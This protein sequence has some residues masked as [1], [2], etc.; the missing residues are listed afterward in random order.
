MRYV[1]LPAFIRRGWRAGLLGGLLLL[2]AGAVQA[3]SPQILVPGLDDELAD[4]IRAFLSI[5][6]E[7]CELVAWRERHLLGRAEEEARDA[8]R[9]FGYYRPEITLDLRRVAGCWRLDVHVTPGERVRV[10]R[11]DVTL[12]GAAAEDPAFEA[13]LADAPLKVG[14]PLRHD[15]YEDLRNGLTRLAADR[16]YFDSRILVRELRIDTG[17][18][19]ADAVIHLDSGPRYAFGEVSLEQDILHPERLRKFLPFAEGEPYEARR[20]ID[21]QQRLVDSDY[22]SEV[23]VRTETEARA[24]GRVPILVTLTPRKRH[25]YLA[26]IG[27]STDI[28]PRLRLGFENRYANQLGHRYHFDLALSPVRSGAG[29]NYEIP[30]ADPTRERINLLTRYQTEETDT[31]ESDIFGV[32]ISHSRQYLSG[33]V[34]TRSLSFEREDYTVA[35]V[36]DRSD[37]LMP[38]FALTRVHADHPLNP[39]R[40]WKLYGSTRGA[41]EE[42]GSTVSFAQFHGRAKLILPLGTGRLITRAEGGATLAD[43]LVEL[44]SSVRFYAGGDDSVRGYGYQKLGPQDASGE[45]IGG[46]HVLTG[47][48]E[49]EHPLGGRWSAAAFVDAGNA[50]DRYEDYEPVIGVGLGIR[51]RS[52]I[53]PIRVDFAHPLDS[54][55]DFRLHL[56]M[57]PDL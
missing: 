40:G 36:T 19:A 43:I 41:H 7:P 18:A 17:E 29:F 8:L 24:G 38:S 25:A 11:V 45:V 16:G 20:L 15:R 27:A 54:D 50:Y 13:L 23:R 46:R 5:A 3:Q 26:G 53:G 51:W 14:D 44:P 52:P 55:D 2:C 12:T 35:G 47:S 9:A 28:G 30:L 34:A 4:N 48:L 32:G 49:Y 39:Q 56:T 10:R 57:G 37:L 31:A 33:W 6:R 1:R 21:L 22:Y 42:A